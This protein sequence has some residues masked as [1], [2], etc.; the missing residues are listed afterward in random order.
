MNGSPRQNDIVSTQY[1]T[2]HIGPGK[3]KNQMTKW[4]KR[5]LLNESIVSGH[6]NAQDLSQRFCLRRYFLLN[7]QLGL[8][9][10]KEDTHVIGIPDK[11]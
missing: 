8:P 4:V 2:I 9:D 3:Q 10:I 5:Y 1:T 11:Q 6:H 7:S